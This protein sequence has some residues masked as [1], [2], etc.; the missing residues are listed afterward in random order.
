[1]SR[2]IKAACVAAGELA[3]GMATDLQA[4]GSA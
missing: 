2:L 1:M 3:A 4:R